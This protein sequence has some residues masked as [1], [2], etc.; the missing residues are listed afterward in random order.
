VNC[1]RVSGL[2]WRVWCTKQPVRRNCLHSGWKAC[3]SANRGLWMPL[4]LDIAL[5]GLHSTALV[6]RFG[7]C[8]LIVFPLGQVGQTTP[9]V[10][11]AGRWCRLWWSIIVA[12]T[13]K[14]K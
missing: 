10:L 9:G 3:V 4:R 6:V 2:L 11:R 1:Q 14:P 5:M 13:R 8:A 12:L 7:V